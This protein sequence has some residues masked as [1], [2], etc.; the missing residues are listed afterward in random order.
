MSLCACLDH[1]LGKYMCFVQAD[2]FAVWWIACFLL[3][4]PRG[5]GEGRFS[6][7]NAQWMGFL[8]R[9]ITRLMKSPFA[10]LHSDS[11]RRVVS[12]TSS[13][14]ALS[15]FLVAGSLLQFGGCWLVLGHDFSC[16]LALVI[17]SHLLQKPKHL[18]FLCLSNL[19]APL[20]LYNASTSIGPYKVYFSQYCLSYLLWSFC[21]SL[22]LCFSFCLSL[23]MYVLLVWNLS[24]I[25][26]PLILKWLN[27]VN[28]TV[29]LFF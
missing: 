24:Q 7:L 28:L 3:C 27:I 17:I 4:H 18:F 29:D 8:S 26:L 21:F 11:P 14:G 1:V 16:T 25:F 13:S 5:G 10:P 9:R 20:H 2:G 23:C 22:Q 12:L 19:N 6:R 15:W